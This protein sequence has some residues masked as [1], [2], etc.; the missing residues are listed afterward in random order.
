[1]TAP[2]SFSDIPAV[3]SIILKIAKVGDA[4]IGLKPLCSKYGINPEHFDIHLVDNLVGA[5]MRVIP[6]GTVQVLIAWPCELRKL[7]VQLDSA[8]RLMTKHS[9]R[10]TLEI[11]PISYVR[12]EKK[13]FR[14][15]MMDIADIMPDLLSRHRLRVTTTTITTIMDTITGESISTSTTDKPERFDGNDVARWIELSRIVVEKHPVD[16]NDTLVEQREEM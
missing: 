4:G 15:K 10:R 16:V 5:D 6:G 3:E 7:K 2:I 1:M 8:F 9:L 14:E 11:V 12:G 13:W